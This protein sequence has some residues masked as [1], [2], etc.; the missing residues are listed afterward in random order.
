LKNKQAI[1]MKKH[2]IMNILGLL[3]IAGL[4]APEAVAQGGGASG[5]IK[6]GAAAP[7]FSLTD[8][9]SGNKVSL[10]D[11]SGQKAVVLIFTSNY[12]PYSRLYETRI[13]EL[14]KNYKGQGV[15]FVMIN[16]ND[17]EQHKEE[18]EES[19][20]EKAKDWGVPYLSDKQQQAAKRYGA[21]KTP[22]VFVLSPRGG[23][24]T[25]FYAGA[26][27]DNPQVAADVSQ[28]YVQNALDGI[29]IGKTVMVKSKRP[30][31]CMIKGT[32]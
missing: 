9:V 25:V 14:V 21:S 18:S 16:S 23:A 26:I 30:V 7:D 4:Y 12:C 3:L 15:A 31:G 6:P 27:D 19:M 2:L 17:P 20:K 1:G 10:A 29:L 28:A 22:E 13:N 5:A 24:F 8:A 32:E 11:F